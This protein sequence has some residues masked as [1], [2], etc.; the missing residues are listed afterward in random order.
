MYSLA[1]TKNKYMSTS[2]R[3]P[4]AFSLNILYV[5]QTV[6]KSANHVLISW[7]SS[8]HKVHDD[9]NKVIFLDSFSFISTQWTRH[10]QC[11][12]PFLIIWVEIKQ[13]KK[14]NKQ[15]LPISSITTRFNEIQDTKTKFASSHTIRIINWIPKLLKV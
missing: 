9:F 4:A 5:F 8:E 10:I 1:S 2:R 11:S 13:K 12:T 7:I 14:R 6:H 3:L 15:F